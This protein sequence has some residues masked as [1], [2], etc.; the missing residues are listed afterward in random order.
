LTYLYTGTHRN[1]DK[2][3]EVERDL[4]SRDREA[5]MT[6]FNIE[7]D[8]QSAELIRL[9]T[10]AELD[11]KLLSVREAARKQTELQIDLGTSS[12]P[13]LVDD[14]RKETVARTREAVHRAQRSLACHKLALIKGDL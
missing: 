12:T 5:V 10:A 9:E 6:K 2:Q 3:V 4:L 1:G 7:Y 11:A 14:L 8:Q 13:D